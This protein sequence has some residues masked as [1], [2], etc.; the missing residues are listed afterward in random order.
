MNTREP[1]ATWTNLAYASVGVALVARQPDQAMVG[2]LAAALV[3]LC[4][5]S[6]VFHW[7]DARHSTWGHRADEAAMYFVFT[8]L[9]AMGIKATGADL[10][11]WFWFASFAAIALPLAIL[12]ER[13]SSFV[14]LPVLYAIVLIGLVVD[15]GW[16]IAVGVTFAFMAAFLIRQL[17]EYQE[18]SHRRYDVL[19]GLWHILTALIIFWIAEVFLA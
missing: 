14:V 3:V 10:P 7:Q 8:A 9:A 15:A 18:W 6:F 2:L 19:H 11:S 4:W 13:I 12:V 16:R 5:G 17:G 1:I